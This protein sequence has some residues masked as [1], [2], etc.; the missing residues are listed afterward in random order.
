MVLRFAQAGLLIFSMAVAIR[1]LAEID[2]N[3]VLSTA[4]QLSA[5]GGERA[6]Q[7]IPVSIT[8]VVTLAEPTWKGLFFVQDSTGGAF[9]N[10]HGPP[11]A[12]GDLVQVDGVSH[13]GGFAPDII[14]PKWKKLGIALLPEARP[15]A[16]ERLMSGAE[17]GRRVEV[18]SV[19]RSVR[20][21]GKQLLVLLL[22][23]GGYRFRAYAKVSTNVEVQSLVG[24]TVRARGTA[25]AAFN[26][27]LRQILGVNIYLPQ[28]SDFIIDHMPSRAI[29]ELPLA[30]LRGILQYRPNESDELRIRVR[31]VVTYQRPGVDIFLQDQTDGLQVRT[32][33]TNTFAPGEIVEAVGF[34]VMEGSLPVLQDAVLI[35][36]T[37]PAGSI[38]S[39]EATIQELRQV[40]HHGDMI[41]L[42]GTL[43]DR[44][45]RP[46]RAGNS[47]SNAP[48]ETILT[49]QCSNYL[50][51]VAAPVTKKFADLASIPIGS[52]LEVSGL[53]LL[54]VRPVITPENVVLDAVQVLLPDIASIR[55]LR[56][57]SWWTPQRLL[58]GLGILLAM[59]TVGA[60]W[61][62][63]ILRKN[64]ALS[65]SIS[66]RAK[67][68]EELQK[69]H[70]LLESR[71]EERTKELRFEI[72]ARKEAE[73]RV[74][75][76][77]EE[78]TRIAQELHDTL[79]QGFTAIGLRLDTLT[80]SLPESLNA[81]KRQFQKILDQSDEYLVEARRAVWELRS[82]ALENT[83]DFCE[84]LKKVSERALE[85]TKIRLDF[86]TEGAVQSPEPAVE[87]NLLRICEEAVANA[88]K[89]GFATQ[90]DVK[91]VFNN[92]AIFLQIRDNGRGF[93]QAILHE[94]DG[95]FGLA[96]IEER[97]NSMAGNISLKTQPGA[98]TEIAVTI[99]RQIAIRA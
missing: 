57:P 93:D 34:P 83:Q 67:A 77:V 72:G 50:V 98:G 41:T 36:T 23:Q 3:E 85:G 86:S 68:Q 8:G 96:G 91:L 81:T 10:N 43:L 59:S 54:Q 37:E 65:A 35:R 18:S 26:L 80:S 56:R 62:L 29:P 46:L 19:V 95:H 61:S 51:S 32:R 25:A 84:A 82:P 70:D 49:L 12:L 44:S 76:I 28:E 17:D 47:A 1:G 94:K 30:S 31:G 5:L 42:K 14:E 75:A 40:L 55:I 9:V 53:C 89:H 99:P 38:V 39:R 6:S 15:I 63:T 16:V 58:P 13:E 88:V 52:A 27:R 33:E 79:L 4:A 97:V 71:V 24:A 69:A 74:D 66:E 90:V 11:P 21:E 48:A 60:I 64:S 73:V 87:G 78:R 45:L 92:Q 7:R 2:T 20:A 22:A